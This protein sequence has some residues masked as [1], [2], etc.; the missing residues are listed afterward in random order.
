[1]SA[2]A[3]EVRA[4]AAPPAPAGPSPEA[5]VR[6][7]GLALLDQAVVSG[8]SFASG[9]LIGRTASPAELGRYTVALTVVMLLVEVQNSLI[10]T[11]YTV[12]RPR[13]AGARLAAY[14]GAA[15][16]LQLALAAAAAVIVA[17]VAPLLAGDG[18]LLGA[19]LAAA[20]LP[21]LLREHMRRLSFAGFEL[22]A[23]LR[24]DVLVA[25]LQLTV[26]GGLA[27]AG[28]LSATTAFLGMGAAAAVGAATWWA[29]QGSG[30]RVSRSEAVEALP[31]MWQAGRWVLASGVA[32]GVGVYAYP[33]LLAAMRGSGAAGVWAA[34]MGLASLANPVLL[35]LGNYLA[36]QTAHAFVARGGHGLRATVGR[37]CGVL[38]LLILP[39]PIAAFV[40]GERALTLVYGA[41]YEGSG[42]L[43]FLLALHLWMM[44]LAFPMSRAFF[45]L[46]R[47]DLE[48]RANL[49]GLL[50]LAVGGVWLV[51]VHGPQGAALGLVVA[52]AAGNAA[53]AWWLRALLRREER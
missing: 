4:A 6:R 5:G 41:A 37:A 15:T 25:G 21:L 30:M 38:T 10:G 2:A 34:G 7:G 51:Q 1:V 13:L 16:F 29:G 11:P 14:T 24:L 46:E 28:R 48:L 43:V 26:L 52:G 31:A 22:R 9:L 12:A 40:A 35:G 19:M 23:A 53:R 32:W 33:W 18:A 49:V 42:L 20:L 27:A 17:G 3:A 39:V 50:V 8:A 44:A 47:A 45:A 36:P